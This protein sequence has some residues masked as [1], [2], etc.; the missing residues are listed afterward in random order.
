MGSIAEVEKEEE[1]D[2]DVEDE[3][4]AWCSCI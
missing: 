3:E 2:E 4:G 1:A